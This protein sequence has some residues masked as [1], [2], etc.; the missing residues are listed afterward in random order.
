MYR[1]LLIFLTL[2]CAGTISAGHKTAQLQFDHTTY[3]F[4]IV[5]AETEEIVHDFTF[6]NTS[7]EAVAILSVST[8]CG[9]ARPVYP[10]EPIAAGSSGTITITYRTKGQQGQV[11]RDI[12]VRY[13]GA[14]ASS[15]ARTTLH[16]RGTITP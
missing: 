6:V 14:T 4:G 12:K 2:L 13:R 11:D 7:T 8:G 1:Y 16:L 9:C 3:D 15:S 10:V 5:S